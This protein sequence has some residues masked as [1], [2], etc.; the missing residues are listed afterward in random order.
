MTTTTH[1]I[2][3][4]PVWVWLILAA[5]F[6]GIPALVIGCALALRT[7]GSRSAFREPGDSA[8]AARTHAAKVTRSG[9]EGLG[10]GL[11]IG[12]ILV[13]DQRGWLAPL[14]CAGGYLLGL[15]AGEYSAQPPAWGVRR[16][17]TLQARRARDYA[18]RW[19]A[20]AVV[21]TTVL[22]LAVPVVFAAAPTI[23]YGRWQPFQGA[24]SF[25]SGGQ[26]AWPGLTVTLGAAALSVAALLLGTAGL[27]RIAARPQPGE[28]ADR[29]IDELQRRQAGRA[30]TG[31]VLA[32]QLIALAALLIAGS[33]GLAVPVP[34]VSPTAYLGSRI[35]IW[36]G[37]GCAAAAALSWL[38][39]SGW[40]RRTRRAAG[41]PASSQGAGP[42][43]GPRTGQGPGT[44]H[45]P[46]AGP[47]SAPG[48]EPTGAAG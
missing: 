33:N 48:A 43:D 5:T 21:V 44:G 41:G 13:L 27:R 9:F 19:A 1:G 17:A 6:A 24:G 42:G 11:L 14:A 32:L 30:I 16:A 10:F 39:L 23:H 45:R 34:S 20:V 3:G 36:T 8:S 2:A 12:L 7:L 25:F 28:A 15:L 31:A 40:I 18:P 37:L 46:G 26:T 29:D 47:G 22:T 35:M 38:V 4:V